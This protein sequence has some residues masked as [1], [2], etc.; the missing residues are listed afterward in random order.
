MVFIIPQPVVCPKC[1][2]KQYSHQAGSCP[3]CFAAFI[4]QHVPT[5]VPDP[6][7]KPFDPNK[8]TTTL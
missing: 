1:G 8:Q 2:H 7:G 4:A 3:A 5:M 6:D